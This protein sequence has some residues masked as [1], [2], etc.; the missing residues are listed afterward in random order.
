LAQ[1]LPRGNGALE[2]N[3]SRF[4]FKANWHHV[5]AQGLETYLEDFV[6]ENIHLADAVQSDY[7]EVLA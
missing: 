4:D 7:L 2:A 3:R 6:K 1:V 5:Y